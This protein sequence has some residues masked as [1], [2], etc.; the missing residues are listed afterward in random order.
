MKLAICDKVL[1]KS[2]EWDILATD[3]ENKD[4]TKAELADEIDKG[5]A[6][7]TQ[8][9]GRRE[10]ENFLAAGYLGL[11]FDRGD[12]DD[13]E[14]TLHDELVS[15]YFG[16]FYFTYSNTKEAPRFRIVLNLNILF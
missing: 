3:F 8:H 1:N 13:V 2:K 7:T 11:D 15:N 4:L 10:R 16:L 5:F 14:A 12:L 9:K 6:F